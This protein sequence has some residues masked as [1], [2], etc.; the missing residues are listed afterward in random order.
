M[1]VQVVYFAGCPSWQ[2]AA[3]RLQ[4][5]LEAT[6]HGDARV[7]LVEVGSPDEA[8]EA[9]FAGSPTLLVDG[10]D[11][12]PGAAPTT[13]LACRVYPGAQGL[14]GSPMFE[15]LAAALADLSPR[16]R[17]QH[18]AVRAEHRGAVPRDGHTTGDFGAGRRPTIVT[19]RSPAGEEMA[20]ST[21]TSATCASC[22]PGPR[23]RAGS[24]GR[25]T[26]ERP[27]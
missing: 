6:G 8:A 23:I 27:G 19:W 11:L 16:G 7:D 17:H 20:P 22:P 2:V 9:R 15:A 21:T 13:Q 26:P 1:R 14:S 10:R 25:P 12:F 5:A 18:R 24:A 3:Q 4:A